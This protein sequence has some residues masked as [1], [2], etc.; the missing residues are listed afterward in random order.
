M[1]TLIERIMEKVGFSIH[2][3]IEGGATH[4]PSLVIQ[5]L[6]GF[7]IHKRIEGGATNRLENC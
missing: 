2:K 1:N 4:R 6:N 3:R 7:S 5:I